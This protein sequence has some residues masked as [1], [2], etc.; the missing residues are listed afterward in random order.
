MGE[1]TMCLF[2]DGAG[3]ADRDGPE[4]HLSPNCFES[5]DERGVLGGLS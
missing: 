3:V 2:E 5:G 1:A 4:F